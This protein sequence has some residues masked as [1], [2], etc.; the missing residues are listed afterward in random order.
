MFAFIYKSDDTLHE[1]YAMHIQYMHKLHVH[2]SCR[3]QPQ[4]I[5]C[6]AILVTVIV[7]IF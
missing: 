3:L 6:A 5:I 2:P 4:M 1:D 7:Y